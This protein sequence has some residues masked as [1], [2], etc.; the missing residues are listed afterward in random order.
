VLELTFPQKQIIIMKN[1][2]FHKISIIILLFLL[3]ACGQA[4]AEQLNQGNVAYSEGKFEK[5]LEQ[6]REA[7]V[8]APTLAEP[9]YNTANTHYRKNEADL[10]ELRVKQAIKNA[11]EAG[12][13]SLAE[14]ALFTLANSYYQAQMLPEAAATYEEILWRNPQ[15]HDARHNLEMVLKQM[16][17]EQEQEQDQHEQDQQDQEDEQEQNQEEQ[18]Q[19]EQEQNQEEQNQQDEEQSDQSGEEESEPESE[20]QQSESDENQPEEEQE[21]E[22]PQ[23]SGGEEESEQNEDPQQAGAQPMEVQPLTPE[24][25][26]QLLESAARDS[27]SLQQYLQQQMQFPNQPINE[28]W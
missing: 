15:A 1:N 24:Q 2:A 28:D 3:T 14:D 10:V 26:A 27:E 21:E 23:P 13:Q 18:D 25:A 20:E 4:G 7:Q 8:E 16:E 17:T 9:F 6:Y 11:E 19:Q 5:A 12:N 22:Q